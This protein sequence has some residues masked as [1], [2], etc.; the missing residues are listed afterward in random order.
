MSVWKKSLSATRRDVPS[1][2]ATRTLI[3]EATNARRPAVEK[4]TQSPP[5]SLEHEGVA[6]QG[7]ENSTISRIANEKSGVPPRGLN[8]VV[9][10]ADKRAATLIGRVPSH[11]RLGQ[12]KPKR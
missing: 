9:L 6:S 7:V 4:A 10:A 1:R 8:R 2:P 5:G 3:L 12:K 11:S